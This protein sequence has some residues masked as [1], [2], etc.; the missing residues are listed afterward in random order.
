MPKCSVGSYAIGSIGEQGRELKGGSAEFA[1]YIDGNV[2]A[3]T[4]RPTP[5]LT[6]SRHKAART[7]PAESRQP[8]L[9]QFIL[10]QGASAPYSYD[11]ADSA[12][13]TE[14]E[15]RREIYVDVFDGLFENAE[16]V[17]LES[18]AWHAANTRMIG[19]QKG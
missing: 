5:P 8:Q 14:Q 10:S 12:H 9:G 16:Y 3:Q 2:C 4:S 15:L 1:R 19:E 13:T 17:R 18:A 11:Q 7:W 6:R